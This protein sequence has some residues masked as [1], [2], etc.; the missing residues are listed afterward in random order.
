MNN[1]KHILKITISA[2]LIG[3]SI[4]VSRFFVIYIGPS[5]RLTVGNV[6]ILLGGI[7]LGPIYGLIIGLIA[8]VIGAAIFFGG[9]FLIFPMI[10]SML[11]GLIP[12]LIFLVFKKI[13]EKIK[14]PPAYIIIGLLLVA[15]TIYVLS[16]DQIANPTDMSA[17]FTLTPLTKLITISALALVVA[18]LMVALYFSDKS[19]K[20]KDNYKSAL[21][22]DFALTIIVT[23]LLVDIIYTPIWKHFV[24]GLPYFFTLFMQI[25]ILLTLIVFKTLLIN[26]IAYAFNKSRIEL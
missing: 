5:F 22:S 3:I 14:L 12:G 26:L 19:L 21:P 4:I 10:S 20:L 13:R 11:Y 18:G 24:F 9:N 2:M 16:V 15:A 23:E 1:R 25:L 8:D 7:V 6:P 17:T